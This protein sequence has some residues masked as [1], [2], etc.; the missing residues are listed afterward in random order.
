MRLLAEVL[1]KRIAR[2][3]DETYKVFLHDEEVRDT[4][5]V[6]LG[7]ATAAIKMITKNPIPDPT[8]QILVIQ[9][10]EKM[11][12]DAYEHNDDLLGAIKFTYLQVSG[13]AE[14]ARRQETDDIRAALASGPNGDSACDV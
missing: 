1:A 13:R 14:E 12:N 10:L 5:V 11:R 7:F 6:K 8:T 2:D 4:P 9:H 3:F